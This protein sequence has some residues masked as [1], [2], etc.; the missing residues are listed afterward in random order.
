MHSLLGTTSCFETE[1]VD[2][3]KYELRYRFIRSLNQ[4]YFIYVVPLKDVGRYFYLTYLYIPFSNQ[5]APLPTQLLYWL[6][7]IEILLQLTGLL[8]KCITNGLSTMMLCSIL[9]RESVII[10]TGTRDHLPVVYL[11]TYNYVPMMQ[12]GS[13]EQHTMI[14]CLAHYY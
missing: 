12:K 10:R 3:T 2:R 13:A 5:P 1:L 11:C 9:L 14:S 7:S 6:S 4:F 8:P